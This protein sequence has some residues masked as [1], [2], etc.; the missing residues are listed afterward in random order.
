MKKGLQRPRRFSCQCARVENYTMEKIE[1]PRNAKKT[2]NRAD[3]FGCVF[4]VKEPKTTVGNCGLD[5]ATIPPMA[6][7][8]G[9]TV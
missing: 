4:Q 1:Q 7:T 5:T 3:G 6:E 8:I 9:G 2:E